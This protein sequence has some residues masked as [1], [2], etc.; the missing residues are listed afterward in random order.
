MAEGEAYVAA[1]RRE[2]ALL[3]LLFGRIHKAGV[4]NSGTGITRMARMVRGDQSNFGN[5]DHGAREY[6]FWIRP[7]RPDP[8]LKFNRK[9]KKAFMQTMMFDQNFGNAP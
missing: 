2:V 4:H 5:R 3:V 8:D 6:I 1:G 7:D 9:V